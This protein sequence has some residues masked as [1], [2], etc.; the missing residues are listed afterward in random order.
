[1]FNP[2]DKVT[3]N[4]NLPSLAGIVNIVHE[5]RL[6]RVFY[7]KGDFTSW[8]FVSNLKLVEAAGPGVYEEMFS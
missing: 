5:V 3:Y 2:G 1:M 4:S 7:A 6:D 8:D